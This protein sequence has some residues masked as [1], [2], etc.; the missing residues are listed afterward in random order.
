VVV[1]LSTISRASSPAGRQ[2]TRGPASR[3]ASAPFLE[4]GL[5][6]DQAGNADRRA[7]HDAGEPLKPVGVADDAG[8]PLKALRL[9]ERLGLPR[10]AAVDDR[11]GYRSYRESQLYTARLIFMLR[12]LDMPLSEAGRVVSA[13]GTEAAERIDA[14]WAS[15]RSRF[16][17][18]Q[19][20]ATLRQGAAAS[21]VSFTTSSTGPNC[22][23]RCASFPTAPARGTRALRRC[24]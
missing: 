20:L 18:Q 9:Y 11:N 24:T 15:V 23:R 2:P 16:A 1:T 8:E 13:S 17:A 7:Q 3:P 22:C 19:I 21:E 14:Y 5:R 6:L 12:L 10:P 4:G